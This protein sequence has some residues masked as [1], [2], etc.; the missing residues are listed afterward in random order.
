V[1]EVTV[2]GE[3]ENGMVALQ[4]TADLHPD[5]VFLDLQIPVMNRFEVAR[6][7]GGTDPRHY[8]GDGIPSVRDPGV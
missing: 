2:I 5:L 8:H 6:N 7:L 4:Q 1:P 3:A